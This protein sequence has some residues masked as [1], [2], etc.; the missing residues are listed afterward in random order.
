MFFL[1]A[2]RFGTPWCNT[3]HPLGRVFFA[4]RVSSPVGAPVLLSWLCW[5]LGFPALPA[6]PACPGSVPDKSDKLRLNVLLG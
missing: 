5:S 4:C 6:P 1:L 3:W 2:D